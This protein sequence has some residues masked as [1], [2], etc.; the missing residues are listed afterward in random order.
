VVSHQGVYNIM[1]GT[2]STGDH[3]STPVTLGRLH[4]GRVCE[5]VKRKM[6]CTVLIADR[7]ST[8]QID[9]AQCLACDGI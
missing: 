2:S 7:E 9:K 5:F 1:V 8:R 6:G 4:T 3:L